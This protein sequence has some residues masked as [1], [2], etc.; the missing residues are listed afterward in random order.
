[1]NGHLQEPTSHC[2]QQPTRRED[3]RSYWKL[4]RSVPRP[5][6][7]LRTT[8]RTTLEPSLEEPYHIALPHRMDAA[9]RQS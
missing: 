4:R 9:H 2:T 7:Q 1:M 6:D 5:K 8:K 3:G